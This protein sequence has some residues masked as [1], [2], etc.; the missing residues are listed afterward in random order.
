MRRGGWLAA[1]AGPAV[2]AVVAAAAGVAAS[3]VAEGS[4]RHPKPLTL[5][6]STL[7]SKP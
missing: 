1:A 7:N 4:L 2:A 5:K 3:V 6:K